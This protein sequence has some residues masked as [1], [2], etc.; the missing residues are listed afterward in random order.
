MTLLATIM[1]V[2]GQAAQAEANAHRLAFMKDSAQSYEFV[3]DG[4]RAPWLK[5]RPE[6]A[7]RMGRQG[8]GN[9]LEGAIFLWTD[10]VG[11]PEVA[12]QVFLMRTGDRPGGEWL[13]EFTSLAAGTFAASR[14]GAV[15]WAPREAGVV[16]K[17]VP[18][19]PKPAASPSQRM[20][21]MRAIAEEFRAEDN[22]G[23]TRW[24]TLRMLATPIARYGRAGGTPEDG[25]LFAFVE[26]TDPEAFLFIE[27]RPGEG[28]LEWQFAGAPMS[29][30][31]L[32][33]ERKGQVVWSL[34]FRDTGYTTN[35]SKPFVSLADRQ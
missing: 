24:G 14:Q 26:G 16:F 2:L 35:L 10:E 1:M 31:P 13:H 20:R 3:R 11:R 15:R 8:S 25:A 9:V 4:D 22:F 17:T 30:W 33:I 34:P 7:F 28:G 12:A 6:P 5:L 18:D 21:Q 27:A 19:A 23:N 29:C 32:R